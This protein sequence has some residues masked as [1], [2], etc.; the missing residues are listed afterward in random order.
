MIFVLQAGELKKCLLM[1][2]LF[3]GPSV[4]S[5]LTK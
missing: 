4:S 3:G 5:G 2:F 1:F